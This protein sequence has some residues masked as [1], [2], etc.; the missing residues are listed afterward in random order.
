MPTKFRTCIKCNRT[1][2]I[3][4]FGL[5]KTSRGGRL[6]KCRS[7]RSISEGHT[8]LRYAKNSA[9]Y[10]GVYIAERALSRFFDNIQRM[11]ICNRGFDFI[12][13]KG[14][15]IDVKSS[16]RRIRNGRNDSW[17]FHIGK[18]TIADY[19]LCLAFDNRDMLNP[20][21]VW[22]IPSSEVNS[23]ITLSI[24]ENPTSLAKYNRFERDLEKVNICCNEMV[25]RASR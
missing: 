6:A 20:E 1:L 2:P 9:S 18:N 23:N 4:S 8:P 24:F 17:L 10:L 22:L 12:C 21:H 16:C 7:C 11:P 5:H 19:F 14:Y 3:T 25:G 15:K 13:G